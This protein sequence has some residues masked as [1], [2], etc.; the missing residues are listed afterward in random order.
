MKMACSF[1]VICQSV[2]LT[3]SKLNNKITMND[4]AVWKQ[5]MQYIMWSSILNKKK[6][7]NKSLWSWT[8]LVFKYSY[9]YTFF[10]FLDKYF[11]LKLFRAVQHRLDVCTFIYIQHNIWI[12]QIYL[13][14]KVKRFSNEYSNLFRHTDLNS[15]TKKKIT[16]N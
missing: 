1:D 8:L 7:N 14:S 2:K 15:F 9:L 5:L 13:F 11:V 3:R 4:C 6:N 12:L 16:T 10:S